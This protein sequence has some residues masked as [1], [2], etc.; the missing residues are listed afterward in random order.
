M[1]SEAEFRSELRK[2][3]VNKNGKIKAED[4]KDD[5]AIIEQ[6]IISSLQLM[7][8]ILELEKLSEEAL[9]VEQLKPGVF[10]NID[11]ICHNFYKGESNA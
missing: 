7:D 6:R 8:L 5:T 9:D 2:W 4:L 11:S 10:K 3:I 1:K